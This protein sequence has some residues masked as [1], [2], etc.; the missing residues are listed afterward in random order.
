MRSQR[1][2][3]A[4]YGILPTA[5]GRNVRRGRTFAPSRTRIQYKRRHGRLQGT[6]A[7]GRAWPDGRDEQRGRTAIAG[8]GTWQLR[9]DDAIAFQLVGRGSTAEHELGEQ[10]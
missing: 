10:A 6:P 1:A 3:F 5:S 7:R 4:M 8:R 9:A 2:V